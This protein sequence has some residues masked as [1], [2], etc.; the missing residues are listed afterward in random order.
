[1]CA[2]S[3]VPVMDDNRT[4]LN[5][6]H[7]GVIYHLG[8]PTP[9]LPDAAPHVPFIPVPQRGIAIALL[10]HALSM[11]REQDAID[12]AARRKA[13]AN[14]VAEW[15]GPTVAPD[16]QCA[17]CQRRHPNPVTPQQLDDIRAKLGPDLAESIDAMV[18]R[19]AGGGVMDATVFALN[20]FNPFKRKPKA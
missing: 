4:E 18:G 3:T 16:P 20:P 8:R 1:M 7:D 10:E 14:A 9:A 11:L 6:T 17:I 5:F 13:V 15:Q 19:L 12:R 2:A